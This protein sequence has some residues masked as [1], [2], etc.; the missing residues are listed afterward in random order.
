MSYQP[1][2]P[3]GGVPP[4]AAAC[5]RSARPRCAA[6][7]GQRRRAAACAVSRR[8][9]LAVWR[10]RGRGARHR[11]GR[12]AGRRSAA[13][14]K[15]ETVKKFAR[16]PVGCTTTLEFEK[17]ATFTLFIET[18]GTVDRRRRRLRRQRRQSTTAP[19]T[20]CR[21]VTLDPRRRATTS[22]VDLTDEQ[23]PTRTTP[24]TS[25]ARP[26]SRSTSPTPGTYR[27]TVTSDDTDFAIAIGGDPEADSSTMLAIGGAVGAGRPARWGGCWWCWGCGARADQPRSRQPAPPSA[28]A[29]P[30]QQ[31]AT[32]SYHAARRRRT[33]APSPPPPYQ[34]PAPHGAATATGGPG[35]GGT[36]GL[37]PVSSEAAHDGD[38]AA[39]DLHLVVA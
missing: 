38:D 37:T 23:P 35:V 10:H 5:S 19:T 17:A 6:V 29:W 16:A 39:E 34:P 1:Q 2:P 24:A 21:S 36:P 18:K 8:R 11:R 27:L 30:P 3:T 28:P 4:G 31:P 26:S 25:R 22:P 33:N 32:P 13:S 7:L 12:R 20:T 9:G 14:T 15:E